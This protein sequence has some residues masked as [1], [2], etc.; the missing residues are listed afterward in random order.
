MA[1]M[2]GTM[3]QI[4]RLDEE[5]ER[6]LRQPVSA[7]SAAGDSASYFESYAHY[8]IHHEMLSVGGRAAARRVW[9][10]RQLWALMNRVNTRCAVSRPL[11]SCY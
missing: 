9:E 7:A 10:A 6:Q 1:T 8:G 4:L 11:C 5:D 3:H 2:R